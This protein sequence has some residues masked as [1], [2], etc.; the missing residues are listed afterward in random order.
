MSSLQN[1]PHIRE[2]SAADWRFDAIRMRADRGLCAL[3]LTWSC[4][5]L[6]DTLLSCDRAVFEVYGAAVVEALLN[7]FGVVEAFD[8]VEQGGPQRRSS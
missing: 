2:S 3:H 1:S 8:V 6:A 5:G 4:P 7:S